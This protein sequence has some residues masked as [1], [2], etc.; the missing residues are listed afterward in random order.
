MKRNGFAQYV[1]MYTK[2]MRLLSSALNVNNRKANFKE[3]V[4]T[5]GA[6][7]VR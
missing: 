5:E 7:A 4:E 3:L 2:V 1:V 6:F